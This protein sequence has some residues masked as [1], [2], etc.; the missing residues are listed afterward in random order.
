MV[1]ATSLSRGCTKFVSSWLCWALRHRW[2]VGFICLFNR[3]LPDHSTKL[4]LAR[5]PISDYQVFN[6]ITS[7]SSFFALFSCFNFTFCSC[8]G[9]V[10]FL[11]LTLKI[12]NQWASLAVVRL[13]RN[14]HVGYE[15]LW[16]MHAEFSLFTLKKIP[17]PVLSGL[18]WARANINVS[19]WP[20]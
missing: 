11:S 19:K 10:E 15:H 17:A 12:N 1:L 9:L 5:P 16:C 18:V 2:W 4:P 3:M 13:L 7:G 14:I 8:S 6:P 20:K